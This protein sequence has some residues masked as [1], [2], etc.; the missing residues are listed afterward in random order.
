MY[1]KIFLH[2]I[3]GE[4]VDEADFM[5]YIFKTR[6]KIGD[7]KMRKDWLNPQ[8]DDTPF[9]AGLRRFCKRKGLTQKAL[10]EKVGIYEVSIYPWFK[11]KY[12]PNMKTVPTLIELGMTASELFGPELALKLQFNTEQALASN[13]VTQKPKTKEKKKEQKKGIIS[14]LVM[15]FSAK[16]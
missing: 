9:Q 13:G 10:A 4:G 5:S 3:F 12:V 15:L 16:R 8:P 11:G 7:I 1:V 6:N 14:R 2:S